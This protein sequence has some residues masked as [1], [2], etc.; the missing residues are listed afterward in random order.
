MCVELSVR[1]H[2]T[3]SI[4]SMRGANNEFDFVLFD[5]GGVLV[6]LGGVGE[7]VRLAGIGSEDEIW[8]RWL[9][10][11]WVRQF[12]RGLCSSDD[13]AAGVVAEWGLPVTPAE[14]LDRFRSWPEGLF[15]G[16]EQLV[17][18]VQHRVKVGC[19]SNTNGVHWAEQTLMWQLGELFDVTFLSHQL[20]LVKPDR[21]LFEH[22]A[23]TLGVPA[24]RV[25]LLDDNV[26]NVVEAQAVG[27]TAVQVRGVDQARSALVDLGVL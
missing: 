16:A 13:F 21:E 26:I 6:R 4:C 5:L 8:R 18:T 15:E 27:F 10:C 19:L 7:M 24:S 17:E 20:G 3:G 12:E 11:P 1:R 25:V 9:S 23:A 2:G 22:V 14:F